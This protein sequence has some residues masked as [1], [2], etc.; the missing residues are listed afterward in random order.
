[1]KE[2]KLK[3]LGSS[4]WKG[5]AITIILAIIGGV[6]MGIL[7]K[8]KQNT[9]YTAERSVVISHKIS[10]NELNQGNNQQPIVIADLN[11]MDTYSDVVQD[12]QVAVAAKKYLSKKLKYQYSAE[13]IKDDVNAITHPQSLVMKIKVRTDS[14]SDS[15]ALVNAVAKGFQE[16]L[17]KIQPG[18][19]QVHILSKATTEDIETN[20]TPNKK[21]YIVVGIALGAL[22]GIIISF[23]AVT[24][25]KYLK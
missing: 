7:A 17:P 3:D 11:M 14:A 5:L 4:F 10:E 25:K 19:G 20:T 13:T 22:V 24:W 18:A 6:C 8:H 12:K 2:Y 1:M 15:V 23:V 9:T 21:K 16:E